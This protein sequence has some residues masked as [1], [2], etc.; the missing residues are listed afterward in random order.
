MSGTGIIT[1]V[2]IAALVALGLYWRVR[3][4]V[5]RQPMRPKRMVFGAVGLTVAGVILLV[6]MFRFFEATGFAE[7]LAGLAVGIAGGLYGLKLTTFG[8]DEEGEYYV[9]NRYLGL[10]VS[11][12]LIARIASRF[13]NGTLTGDPNAASTSAAFQQSYDPISSAL[14]FLFIGYYAVYYAGVLLE[15]RK[16][17]T[18]TRRKN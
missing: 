3:R 7:V 11:A 2:V 14:L 12:I 8:K 13:L 9:P 1:T 6:F 16:T 17:R 5:G 10:A 18:S 15:S 4:S